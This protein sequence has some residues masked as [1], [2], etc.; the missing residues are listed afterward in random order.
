MGKLYGNMI[1]DA[2][3]ASGGRKV[4]DMYR[5]LAGK[6]KK[7][8]LTPAEK[9]YAG[10]LAATAGILYGWDMF[11]KSQG[12]EDDEWG[13]RYVKKVQTDEGEKELVMTWSNP[14]N[15]FLKYGYRAHAAFQPDV[16]KPWVRLLLTNKWEFHPIWRTG[17]ELINN[18]NGRGDKIYSEFESDVQKV[19]KSAIYATTHIVAL[20]GLMDRDPSNVEAREQFKKE[21]GQV[22]EMAT[23]PFTFTYMRSPE[24]KRRMY[25]IR[26]IMKRFRREL[27]QQQRR[28]SPKDATPEE[29]QQVFNKMINELQTLE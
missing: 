9:K 14:A 15:I 27:S 13:R 16:Q 22:L 11:W 6:E 25:K 26:S 2:I 19:K 29:K 28:P 21:A 5:S 20:L 3:K 17:Y 23:R 12:F 8:K 1:S 7:G 18:D 4:T 10:G 24:E